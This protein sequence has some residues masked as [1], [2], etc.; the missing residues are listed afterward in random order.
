M[1]ENDTNQC[2]SYICL[3]RGDMPLLGNDMCTCEEI[4]VVVWEPSIVS[5][6]DMSLYH[7]LS[8]V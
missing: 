5:G 3:L 2:W 4:H 7:R 8:V 1:F 6:D